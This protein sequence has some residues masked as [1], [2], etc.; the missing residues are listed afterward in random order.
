V[1][2]HA[3]IERRHYFVPLVFAPDED[4]EWQTPQKRY[5]DLNVAF[6]GRASRNRR[7]SGEGDVALLA[8]KCFGVVHDF[9]SSA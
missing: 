9:V 4:P 2:R 6:L 3:W 8:E 7:K 1:T 5:L